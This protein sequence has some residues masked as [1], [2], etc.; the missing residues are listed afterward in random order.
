MIIYRPHR[1]GVREAIEEAK[2]FETIDEMKQYIVE[3]EAKS[4]RGKLFDIQDIVIV[5]VHPHND[6][7][8][9]WRHVKYVCVKRYGNEDY[10][11]KYG[12]SQCIGMCSED[13]DK[14][15]MEI[16]EKWC[17]ENR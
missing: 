5:D 8:I 3:Y 16:F 14:N 1:G 4:I 17:L 2:E 12:S 7:R 11:K 10:M 15:Y 9:G 6:E 13:Y